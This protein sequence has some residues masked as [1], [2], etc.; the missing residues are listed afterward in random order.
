MIM[1]ALPLL[2]GEAFVSAPGRLQGPCARA[3]LRGGAQQPAGPGSQAGWGVLAA[4]G[5][6]AAAFALKAAARSRTAG[7]TAAASA[8][9]AVVGAPKE[10]HWVKEV[11]ATLP[12]CDPNDGMTRWDP[13]GLSTGKN[14]ANFDQYR[15]AEVKHGRIAMLA[16]VGLV[17]QH[18]FRFKAIIG[19]E[20][21]SLENVPSGFQAA[22]TYPGSVG[23]AILFLVA[24]IIELG[25]LSD[26]DNKPGYF[27]DPLGWRKNF[28][29]SGIDAELETME[30]EHGRLAM[31]GVIGTLWAEYQT[32]YDA[33][34]QWEHATEGAGRLFKLMTLPA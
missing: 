21:E 3:G 26:E 25:V 1:D 7:R 33:V 10:K 17:T 24:G 31:F 14:A 27:G 32:G 20:V 34:E 6:V 8:A 9:S 18:Y 2:G 11:G 19:Q 13:L 12:L 28:E 23:F 4:S 15:A 5:S 30:L 29:Y 16:T 22:T